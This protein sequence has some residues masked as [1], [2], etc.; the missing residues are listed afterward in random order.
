MKG[1]YKRFGAATHREIGRIVPAHKYA[2]PKHFTKFLDICFIQRLSQLL[3]A[4]IKFLIFIQ[5]LHLFYSLIACLIDAISA[6]KSALKCSDLPLKGWVKPIRNNEGPDDQCQDP[7]HRH[8]VHLPVM[9]NGWQQNER[10]S[11]GYDR[12]EEES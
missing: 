2:D 1:T 5:S 7:S 11:D 3:K 8:K 9:D 6:G 12:Y 4:L 10:E